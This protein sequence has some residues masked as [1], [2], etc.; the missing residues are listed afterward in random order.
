[1][2]KGICASEYLKSSELQNPS[3]AWGIGFFAKRAVPPGFY[4]NIFWLILLEAWWVTFLFIPHFIDGETDTLK[5]KNL[6]SLPSNSRTKKKKDSRP[7]T[8][9]QW[10]IAI[11]LRNKSKQRMVWFLSQHIQHFTDLILGCFLLVVKCYLFKNKNVR[12]HK[13]QGFLLVCF[14][15]FC[16]FLGKIRTNWPPLVSGM[17]YHSLKCAT[18]K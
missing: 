4:A 16:S 7:K 1:M 13:C 5:K 10:S 2:A 6:P 8:A 18:G 11:L 9:T 3:W 12:Y 14:V 15:L 17:L